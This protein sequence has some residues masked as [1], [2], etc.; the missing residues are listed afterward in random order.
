MGAW[1]WK[2]EWKAATTSLKASAPKEMLQRR[3]IAPSV[4]QPDEPKPTTNLRSLVGPISRRSAVLSEAT[5]AQPQ[6]QPSPNTSPNTHPN[7]KPNPS[8]P[9]PQPHRTGRGWQTAAAIPPTP[10]PAGTCWWRAAP[11]PPAPLVAPCFGKR[12][13]QR[14]L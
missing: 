1:A 13:G 3:R 4:A 8:Q 11:P 12:Q 10:S 14:Q 5:S 9:Q 2:K 6:P 7:P